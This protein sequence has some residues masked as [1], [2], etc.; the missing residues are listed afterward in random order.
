VI[1]ADQQRPPSSRS[2]GRA[3]LDELL[4]RAAVRRPDALA[5]VDPPDRESFTDGAPRRLTYAETDRIVSAIAG[6]LRRLGLRAD[7]IVGIQVASTVESALSLLG[8]LR[9]GLIAMP[10]P[11]L[12]RRAEAIAALGRVGVSALIVGG[13]LGELDHYDLA[14]QI[15]AEAFPVR[16]V[17]GFGARLPDGVTSLDDVRAMRELGPVP[18]LPERAEEPAAHVAVITW[19]VCA[20]GLVPVAR[21]HAELIAAGL[22][23]VLEAEIRPEPVL[24]STLTL[25]S[26]AAFAAE[27]VPWLIRGGT[28]V[29]HQPFDADVFLTQI[30]MVPVDTVVLPGPLASDLAEVGQ[31]GAGDYTIMGVWR[32]PERLARARPWRARKARLTDVQV[33]GEAG[34][35]AARRGEDGMPTTFRFEVGFAPQGPNGRLMA[36]EVA[37]TPHGT[38]ALRGPMVPRASFPAG[39]E[40]SGLPCLKIAPSGFLDTGYACRAHSETL[41]LR[42]PPPGIV[43]VGGCR[44]AL[45]DL[46]IPAGGT[47]TATL[48]VLP[49][50]L[51]GHRLAGIAADHD[52][53]ERALASSGANSLL[54]GAFRK[55]PR[56]AA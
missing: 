51:A 52:A 24:L 39:A 49:D 30:D 56:Q 3:T 48:A 43:T 9:A 7:A 50:I 1:L 53:V 31:L 34:L 4:R 42:A 15:A 38:V 17:C 35:L 45:R 8:V 12:W 40:R 18:T 33:F 10:L 25:S 47:G 29:L 37:P 20:D 5:L 54:T 14:M 28:L 21:S 55:H 11:L 22:A 44:L 23:L 32:A 26:F 19:D 41:V 36:V 27:V 16:H 6:R 13:R 2:G 46:E